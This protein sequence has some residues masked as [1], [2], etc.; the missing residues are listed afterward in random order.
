[1]SDLR[2]RALFGLVAFLL[3]AVPGR[4][5]MAQ[6]HDAAR[7]I[8]AQNA[9]LVAQ[10]ADGTSAID[11]ALADLAQLRKS[12]DDLE[13]SMHRIERSAQ[14]HAHDGEFARTVIEELR[15]LPKPGR[16]T[17]ERIERG[18][19]LEATSDADLRAERR[20]REL[21]DLDA[22]VARRLAGAQPPVPEAQRPQV[23][24]AVRELLAEQVALLARL[25]K[26]RQTLMQTLRETIDAERDLEQ[27]SDAARAELNRLLFWIPVPPGTR[28][29]PELAQ[30]LAWTTSPTNW[31]AAG[32]VLRDEAMRRP[33][34]PAVALVVA[35]GLFAGRRRLQRGLVSL[36][37][38]AVTYE[39]Y[40]IGHALVA[41]AITLALALP[42]P[43]VMWTVGNLLRFAPDTQPFA[44]VVG[45]VL[46][47]V[48]LLVL[49]LSTLAWLLDR[50]GVGVSHF[51]WDERSLTF[52]ARALRRFAA[53]FVPMV[54]IA[55]LNLL[56]HAPYANRE[57]LGRLA[58]NVAMIALA[59]F[60]VYLLRRKSPLMQR[61]FAHA[62]RS[63]PFKLH[64]VWLGALIAVPLG[65]AALAVAGYFAA[66]AYFFARMLD[67]LFLVI[68][69]L[70]LYGLIALWVRVQGSPAS[71]AGQGAAQPADAAREEA[72]S[73]IAKVSSPRLDIAAIGEQT[74]SLLD[75]LITL[76]LLAEGCVEYGATPYRCCR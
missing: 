7:G 52:V 63:W 60:L 45:D 25:G 64:A 56:E 32:A 43:I 4:A 21:G 14:V 39:R 48:A 55:A 73:E 5:S 37:P 67:S 18:R 66:A 38:A 10:I 44:Q 61:L 46:P 26:L 22:A 13:E 19:M 1:M 54:F 20:L 16:F 69:A 49:A 3:V 11:R 31:R 58:M 68:G 65:T 29:V 51:G 9:E 40:R 23:E 28:T 76:V 75:V 59:V 2:C 47:R 33:F 41:L 17:G 27:R 70:T 50:R 42:G 35:A 74:R 34:W 57:S 53:L 8:A 24:A 30:S 6:Q 71:C 62:P 72:R 12:K 15:V 36:A